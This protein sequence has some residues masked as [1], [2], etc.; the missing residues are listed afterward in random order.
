MIRFH[1][2]LSDRS[3]YLRYFHMEKLST[4]VAHDRLVR[5]CSVD[6]DQEMALVAECEGGTETMAGIIGVG[7]LVRAPGAREAEVAVLVADVF[8]KLGLGSELLSRLIQ[9]G[10]DKELKRITAIVLPEN[11]AMRSI[12]ARHGFVVS[13][14]ED[15]TAIHLVL[16]L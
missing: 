9:F 16:S 15:L 10:R 2:M 14:S 13:Q 7:R 3:T 11:V 6:Y 12:A 4:R 5:R 1:E 8:Q